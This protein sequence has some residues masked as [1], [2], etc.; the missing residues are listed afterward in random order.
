MGP[1]IHVPSRRQWVGS[2][3][4]GILL[5]PFLRVGPEN[6]AH[7]A[8]RKSKRLLLFC[9]MG[10]N[11]SMWTPTGIS[12]ETINTFSKM[13]E[14][15]A[16]IKDSIVLVEGMPSG[17]INDAHGAPDA[18]TGLGFG[19][20]NGQPKVSVDQFVASKL[21]GLGINRPIASLLLGADTSNGS[22]TM[23]Y[24][25]AA[26]G[27]GNL[28]TIGSPLSAFTT[29]FGGALPAGL[30]AAALLK[31]RQSMLDIVKNEANALKNTLGA[32][33]RGKLDRHLDSVR[34]LE[35]KL[36]TQMPAGGGCT[37][38]AAPG[39]DSTFNYMNAID[40]IAANKIHLDVIVNAFAC[41]ITRVAAIQ[42]G[43]DQKFMVNLPGRVPYDDQH[44]GFLHSGA[45]SNF[46]N[47]VE[48]ERYLAEQFVAVVTKLKGLADPEDATKTL[49]D[50]TL[51]AWCRDMGDAVNHDQKSMRF[52]LASGTGGYL[53]TAAGGRYIRST[54]RHE[55]ILLNLAEA[56]GLTSFA[57]FGDPGLTGGAKTPLANIAAA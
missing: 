10:T 4:A 9:T 20:Y 23:F 21:P 38:P 14:P 45:S 36:M 16:P 50:T 5:S 3:G 56:M 48:F 25:G 55:R 54:E 43:N 22:N 40:G 17:N 32:Q 31:R 26:N 12:G 28:P 2:V 6:Q 13:T 47:L 37:K 53:K 30:S 11:P 15:L 1:F 51:V 7:A 41:D 52:V 49:F 34:Q 44:G 39:A 29:V 24:G 27:G 35:N 57:G 8:I 19:Y 46:K 33:E 42:F 18:L